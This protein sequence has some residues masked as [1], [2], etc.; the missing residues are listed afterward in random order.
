[1][2]DRFDEIG[3]TSALRAVVAV[4]YDRMVADDLLATWFEG[5]DLH[6]LRRHQVEFLTAAIGGPSDYDGRSIRDAHVDLRITDEAFDRMRAHLLDA[7]V[8][9]GVAPGHVDDI[10]V[11]ID[12]LRSDV[13]EVA[14]T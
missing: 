11:R 12:A 3:G 8:G 13:V 7:L 1:M 4:L 10:G 6:R 2:G 5:V 9:V 14:A